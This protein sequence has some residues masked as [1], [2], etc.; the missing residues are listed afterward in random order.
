[1]SRLPARL[2]VPPLALLR[3][4]SRFLRSAASKRFPAAPRSILIL[5]SMLLGDSLMLFALLRK[6]RDLYP[7]ARI[8]LTVQKPLLDLFA[9]RPCGVEVIEF[10]PK[11]FDTVR[12][13]LRAGPFDL[14]IIP[15]ENHLTWL[16]RAAGARHI[17]GFS[18]D[19]PDRKNWMLDT[20]VDLP[21]SPMALGDLFLTLLPGP[22]PAPFQPGDWPFPAQTPSSSLPPD[23]V[24]FHIASTQATRQW[25]AQNWL[26]L[27]RRLRARGFQPHWSLGPGEE[28]LLDEHDPDREFPILMLR[29]APMWHA[30]SQARLLV[31]IDTSMVHLARLA[32]TPS[33][34]LHGPTHPSLFGGGRFWQNPPSLPVVIDD[35]PCRDDGKVFR[36]P[37]AWARICTRGLDRCPNPYCIR[38]LSVDQVEQAINQLIKASDSHV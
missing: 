23:S 35:V 33:V 21:A 6:A 27:G 13:V 34:V 25:P 11:R 36:R 31:S 30:L 18:G 16:A 29:F 10:N 8:F 26:E 4:A 12:A 37:V 28:R 32:G 5:H 15:A 20:A 1:M 9:S 38:R 17:V 7:D 19:V 24:V 2:L 22:D 3:S 14:A